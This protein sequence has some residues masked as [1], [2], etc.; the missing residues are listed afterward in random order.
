MEKQN[1]DHSGSSKMISMY[2]AKSS[3]NYDEVSNRFVEHFEP[4]PES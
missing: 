4:I 2:M 1:L 3:I